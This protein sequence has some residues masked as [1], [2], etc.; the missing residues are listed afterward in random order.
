[1]RQEGTQERVG[2]FVGGTI[3]LACGMVILGFAVHETF[4]V[5]DRAISAW[6]LPFFYVGSWPLLR[7]GARYVHRA[8]AVY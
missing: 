2:S 1:M 5:E 8:F 4:I 3:V 6:L 7:R